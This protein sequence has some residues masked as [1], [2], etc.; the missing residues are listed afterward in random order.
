MT[1][2]PTVIRLLQRGALTIPGGAAS[3]SVSVAAV[4]PNRA[5][6]RKLGSSI[7]SGSSSDSLAGI[8]L[9]NGTTVTAF[10][11]TAGGNLVIDWELVDYLPQFVSRVQ[12]GLTNTPQVTSVAQAVAAMNPAKSQLHHLGNSTTDT[13]SGNFNGQLTRVEMASASSIVVYVGNA[14]YAQTTSWEIVEFK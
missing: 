13:A 4:D 5:S 3:A 8:Y 11:Q 7:N 10:R 12:R 9:A 1:Y 6:L 14:I 2:T